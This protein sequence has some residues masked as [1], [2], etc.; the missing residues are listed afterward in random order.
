M[1]RRLSRAVFGSRHEA[2]WVACYVFWQWSRLWT[3]LASA[4]YEA[5]PE[6]CDANTQRDLKRFA[7]N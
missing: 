3:R 1:A 5:Q 6:R 7:L 2:G 4:Q